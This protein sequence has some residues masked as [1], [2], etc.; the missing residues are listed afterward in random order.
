MRRGDGT[1]GDLEKLVGLARIARAAFERFAA[2][3][4]WKPDL[5]GLCYDATCFLRRMAA[6]QG[7]ATDAG[8]GRGH[9]FVL[10]G[11]TVVDITSTQFGQS[12]RVAVLPLAEAQKRGPWWELLERSS[13]LPDAEDRISKAVAQE[14]EEAEGEP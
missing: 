7:I 11:D 6:A 12:D 10:H 14:V 13:A 4:N 3:D 1:M 2:K 8:M 5:G 9:W